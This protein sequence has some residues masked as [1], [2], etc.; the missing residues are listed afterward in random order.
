[1]RNRADGQRQA[2]LPRRPNDRRINLLVLLVAAGAAASLL[3][4]RRMAAMAGPAIGRLRSKRSAPG[5]ETWGCPCG[6]QYRL[7]GLGRHR[8][9]WPQGA[10]ETSR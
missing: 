9:Y 3:N 8:I 10:P 2:M 7:S 1:M 4:R 5:H 6:Q